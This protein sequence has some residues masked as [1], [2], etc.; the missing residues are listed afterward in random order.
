MSKEI[1]LTISERVKTIGILND[2][3]GN[4][5]MLAKILDDIKKIAITPEEWTAAGLV[6]TPVK[7]A[8][9]ELTGQE[10]WNWNDKE[11]LNKTV[12]LDGDTILYIQNALK[13]KE[14]KK[15]ISLAD[16]ALITLKAK[17]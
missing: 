3:K 15:E 16:G 8:Q 12:T 1:S 5:D 10:T 4:L 2:F 11:E 6:K 9:G 13:E 7:N 14:D 17:L